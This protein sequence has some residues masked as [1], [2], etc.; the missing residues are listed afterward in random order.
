[1]YVE[2]TEANRIIYET[3]VQ[4]AIEILQREQEKKQAAPERETAC[5]HKGT[6]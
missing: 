6:A 2:P 4:V 5:Q 3:Y 1:M